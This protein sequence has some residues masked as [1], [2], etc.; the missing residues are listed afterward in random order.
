MMTMVIITCTLGLL[1]GVS[2]CLG[3]YLWWQLRRIR[4]GL[5]HDGWDIDAVLAR[6]TKHE[7]QD[8]PCSPE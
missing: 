1:A 3:L 5:Y 4:Q 7:E 2:L 8:H 6:L